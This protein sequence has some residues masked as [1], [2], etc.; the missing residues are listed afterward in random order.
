MAYGQQQ[1]MSLFWP[2]LIM[3][4]V[5]VSSILLVSQS[6]Y[7]GTESLG[8]SSS[9]GSIRFQGLLNRIVEEPDKFYGELV[10]VKATVEEIHSKQAF[11]ISDL[12]TGN[13][14][15]ILTTKPIDSNSIESEEFYF[16]EHSEV[17]IKGNLMEFNSKK[18]KSDYGIKVG[19][20]IEES[21]KDSPV[22][23]AESII[24]SD[25]HEIYK[26]E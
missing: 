10:T 2:I 17:S 11:T 9:A 7:N 26:F 1:N 12:I 8:T 3:T 6:N 15:L 19:A 23:I 21:H 24:F 4:I 18:L 22:L 20:E 5:S 25:R 13:E 16:R 14:L